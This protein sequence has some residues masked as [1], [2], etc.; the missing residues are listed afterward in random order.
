LRLIAFRELYLIYFHPQLDG[1][2]SDIRECIHCTSKGD[3]F[4]LC[5][6]GQVSRRKPGKRLLVTGS[7]N[8][9]HCQEQEKGKRTYSPE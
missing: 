4:T 8:P 7:A 1:I 2:S 6:P 9:C 3:F 5:V